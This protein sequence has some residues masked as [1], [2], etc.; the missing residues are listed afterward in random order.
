MSE[1]LFLSQS[2]ARPMYAQI[3]DQIK[4][5][6]MAGDWPPGQ[7]LP[8]IRELAAV[9]KVSVITVKRAY[10]D[11]EEAGLIATKAGRG[12]FVAMRNEAGVLDDKVQK[13]LESAAQTAIK[14]EV[15]EDTLIQHLRVIY[16]RQ[17]GKK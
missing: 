2:D 10:A 1:E 12:S 17:K 16:N 14:A 3:F 13:A 8:S 6:I 15:D 4:L 5:K 9:T 11:L 7:P